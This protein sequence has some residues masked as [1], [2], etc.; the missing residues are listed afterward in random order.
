MDKFALGILLVS[1]TGSSVTADRYPGPSYYRT[2]EQVEPT[3]ANELCVYADPLNTGR[4]AIFCG[5]PVVGSDAIRLVPE[6]PDG[7]PKRHLFLVPCCAVCK[8][9]FCVH[10][11][12]HKKPKKHHKH[13]DEDDYEDDCARA[14]G[15]DYED[16]YYYGRASGDYPP[17]TS[18]TTMTAR[19]G[20]GSHPKI[21][22]RFR[23]RFRPVRHHARYIIRPPAAAK[24]FYRVG[25][26]KRDAL[27][28]VP[29][30]TPPRRLRYGV[31][32]VVR[33]DTPIRGR[34]ALG[35]LQTAA[36]GPYDRVGTVPGMRTV[37]ARGAPGFL[38]LLGF[39]NTIFGLFNVLSTV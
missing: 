32:Y 2:E 27:S 39:M 7:R 4:N 21:L 34:L 33:P 16:G 5:D 14:S 25:N 12:H 13:D 1:L 28:Y 23:P 26:A 29:V 8:S 22:R 36:G 38:G 24:S 35:L 11:K 6:P 10:K 19:K 17:Q 37:P 31:R 18:T 3:A 30:G 9:I 20:F 15:G